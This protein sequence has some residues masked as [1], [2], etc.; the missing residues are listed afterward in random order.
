MFAASNFFFHGDD[1]DGALNGGLST[2]P[3]EEKRV[4]NSEK[5]RSRNISGGEERGVGE[6]E[7]GRG[8]LFFFLSFFLAATDS[9]YSPRPISSYGPAL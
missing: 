1:G 7:E 4:P 6:A 5:H 2:L 9:S 3:F 8:D